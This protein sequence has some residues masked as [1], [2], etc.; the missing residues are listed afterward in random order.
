M[1][2]YVL[3][4]T[5]RFVELGC[6]A[7]AQIDGD[8]V[9]F[10]RFRDASNFVDTKMVAALRHYCRWCCVMFFSLQRTSMQ[11]Q[12]AHRVG[13][14]LNLLE[15]HLN[16]PE[17]PWCSA[18]KVYLAFSGY[19]VAKSQLDRIRGAEDNALHIARR[20]VTE[21]IAHERE[22]TRGREPVRG[23]RLAEQTSAVRRGEL[24]VIKGNYTLLPRRY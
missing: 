12:N 24:H 3:A 13:E 22:M 9:F 17:A 8:V 11:F 5:S 10:E 18:W 19:R 1:P 6:R 2:I 21:Q 7:I 20:V 15:Y 4:D 16:N 23:A 14:T